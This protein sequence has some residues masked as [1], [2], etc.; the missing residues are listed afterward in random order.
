MEYVHHLAHIGCW[1]PSFG[2]L[3]EGSGLPLCDSS[4][5]SSNLRKMLHGK[6]LSRIKDPE[7]TGI[8]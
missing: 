7:Q 4:V 3:T 2:Y 1:L 6:V 5:N 8:R